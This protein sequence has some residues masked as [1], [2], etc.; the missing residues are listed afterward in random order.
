[1]SERYQFT[2]RDKSLIEAGILLLRKLATAPMT[3][4]GQLKTVTK[5]LGALL[6]LPEVPRGLDVSIMITSPTRSFPDCI[7]TSHSWE[8]RVEGTHLCLEGGG[9]FARTDTSVHDAFTSMTWD[10]DPGRTADYRDYREDCLVVPDLQTFQAGVEL[11]SFFEKGYGLEMY[12]T[13]NPELEEFSGSAS[14]DSDYEAI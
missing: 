6:S 13:D 7:R 3:K 12:D 11:I 4:P 9:S 1:M 2:S 14:D 8:I 5:V 10:A